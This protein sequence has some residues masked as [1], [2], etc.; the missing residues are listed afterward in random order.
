MSELQ[1]A[2]EQKKVEFVSKYLKIVDEMG[3]KNSLGGKCYINN[4]SEVNQYHISVIVHLM[5]GLPGET[6]EDLKNTVHFINQH[7]I[8][9]V[10]IHSCY[11][12]KNTKLCEMY[13]KAPA[14]STC[15]SPSCI[16]GIVAESERPLLPNESRGAT[17]IFSA[18]L[19]RASTRI[20]A[21]TALP[22]F[23]CAR[24]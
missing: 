17:A 3:K 12:V 5:I 14:F 10:K 2:I 15:V 9:G 24:G 1:Y 23:P 21:V 13:Q 16:A 4:S 19:G 22:K 8:Q 7:Q 20:I 18:P 6:I 11:V